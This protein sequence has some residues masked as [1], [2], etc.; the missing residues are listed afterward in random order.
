MSATHRIMIVNWPVDKS[1][2]KG[3]THKSIISRMK[4][5]IK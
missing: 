5:S 1:S 2:F 4:K 3:D